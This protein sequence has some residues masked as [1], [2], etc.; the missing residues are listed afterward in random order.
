MV[1]RRQLR[2]A[3]RESSRFS[4]GT[5]GCSPKS[6]KRVYVS[7][8]ITVIQLRGWPQQKPFIL[9]FSQE[10]VASSKSLRQ[11]GISEWIA[12][13]EMRGW[14]Q[15]KP[16][17]ALVLVVRLTGD[18]EDTHELFPSRKTRELLEL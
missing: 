4:P 16:L 8:W 3:A 5:F 6:L 14:L 15:Q 12:V 13:T 17:I 9:Q 7:E 2:S 10:L 1:Q 11:T 18:A